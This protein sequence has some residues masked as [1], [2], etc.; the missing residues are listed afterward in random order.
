MLEALDRLYVQEKFFSFVPNVALDHR[1]RLS[2]S[3]LTYNAAVR[4]HQSY[5]DAVASAEVEGTEAPVVEGEDPALLRATAENELA[6]IVRNAE[7]FISWSDLQ[8]SAYDSQTL[9][10]PFLES[11]QSDR[12]A[13]TQV[14]SSTGWSWDRDVVLDELERVSDIGVALADHVLS[15]VYQFENNVEEARS[16]ADLALRNCA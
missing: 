3:I 5:L 2:D 4:S 16:Y 14:V 7:R 6:N 8:A 11:E 12:E 1:N 15:R 9:I 10:E 13:F